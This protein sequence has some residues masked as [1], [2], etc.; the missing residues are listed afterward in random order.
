MAEKKE[1]VKLWTSYESYFE[2]YSA[3]EVGRLVLAMIKY[4]ASGV[5]PEFSGSE[6][7]IWPAI[8][9][10]IDESL[11]A[12]AAITAAN[13]E[14]GKKGGRPPKPGK[15]SGF[16]ENP[17]NPTG[18]EV[19][20]K[21]QGQGQGQGQGHKEMSSDEDIKKN[22]LALVMNAYMNHIDPVPSPSSMDELKSYVKLM[23][24]ECCIR[25]IDAALNAKAA[26][27]NYVRRVLMNKASQGVR[28]IADWDALEAKREEAKQN[29]S[30][31][32]QSA[33]KAADGSFRGFRAKSALDDAD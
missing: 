24:A 11:E 21:R 2:E 17:K 30:G 10:D 33:G 8:R 20:E 9:R 26:N 14:N 18:F 12:Q 25:A 3:A 6:R 15:E 28:C 1:Y 31:N 16:S 23:G 29:G 4:R 22:D 5:E 7:F 32:A 27:W 19:S 13:R